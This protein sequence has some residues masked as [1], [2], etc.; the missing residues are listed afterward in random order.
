MTFDFQPHLKNEIVTLR[1]LQKE[2]FE[3]LYAVA[4]DPLIWEQHPNKERYKREVFENFFEGAVKSKGA[5]VIF[6]S[7]T[8]KAI[9]STRFYDLNYEKKEV[10]I[11][12]TFLAKEYWGSHYN[13]AAKK[14]LINHAFQYVDYIIFHIGAQNI[15][16]QKAIGK[17]GALKIDEISVAYY[18]EPEKRNF[19][20]QIDKNV[21]HQ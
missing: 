20:Y 11:G 5:F 19:V 10:I 2:D 7:Q 4:A 8:Q 6:D 9:G 17:L 3:L 15:R 14:L 21:W 1:P 12:Y 18:G 16:S 13:Q